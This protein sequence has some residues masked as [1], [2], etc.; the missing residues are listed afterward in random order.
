MLLIIQFSMYFNVLKII[1]KHVLEYQVTKNRYPSTRLS[2]I[3]Y[4]NNKKI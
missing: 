2:P 4:A 3:K 1:T